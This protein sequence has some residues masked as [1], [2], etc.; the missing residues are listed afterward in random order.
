MFFIIFG[1]ALVGFLMSLYGYRVEQELKSYANFKPSCD[2]TDCSKAFNSK[3]SKLFGISN[4]LTGM[5][6]YVAIMILAICDYAYLIFVASLASVVMSI[7]F[8]YL[9]YFKIKSICIVCTTVY[10]INVALFILS[11]YLIS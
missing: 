11:W 6:F 10:A 2:I 1:L 3:Y 8:A 7:V 5:I 4:T 9:L